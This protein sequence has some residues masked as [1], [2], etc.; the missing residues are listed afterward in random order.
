MH[1]RAADQQP[2]REGSAMNG[3]NYTVTQYAD[4]NEW[5]AARHGIGASEIGSVFGYGFKSRRELWREKTGRSMPKDLS[6]NDRVRFGNEAEDALRGLFRVMHP[7]YELSFQPFTIY[8]PTGEYDF[9]FYT[10]DGELAER[11]T[12]RRGL[13]ESKTALCLSRRDWDKWDQKI[14]DGYLCQISQGMFCGNFDFAVLF[15]LLRDHDGDA[16]L[17]AYHVERDGVSW[18]IDAILLEGKRFWQDV[19]TGTIPPAILSL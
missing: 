13:Y 3:I 10:P 12:G 16:S 14:P 18:M 11:E 8:R 1:D 19:Q 7:E 9:L 17:R 2:A 15:A 4:R 5:L 6:E